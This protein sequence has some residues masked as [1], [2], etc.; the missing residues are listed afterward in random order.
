MPDTDHSTLP[1]IDELRSQRV[2]VR[3]YQLADAQALQAAVA[4]SREHLRPW[5]PFAD[6]HQNIEESA[7]WIS[8][9]RGQWLL[10]EQFA[11]SI[12]DA[13]TGRFLGGRRLRDRLLA[14]RRCARA[15]LHV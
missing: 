5:L 10:R 8:G 13:A 11:L 4:Q 14:A 3:P 2:I 7:E 9:A 12:W 15:W 6:K 1:L